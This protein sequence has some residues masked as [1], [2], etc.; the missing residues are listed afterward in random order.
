MSIAM[1]EQQ[2]QEFEEKGF[3]ILEDFFAQDEL[4]RLLAAID[5]VAEKVHRH[6][7]PGGR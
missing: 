3:I 2:A 1:T 7:R 4:N 6:K 5:E